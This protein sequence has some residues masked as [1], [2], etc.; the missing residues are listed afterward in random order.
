MGHAEKSAGKA[1]GEL[2]IPFLVFLHK[3]QGGASTPPI[4][5]PIGEAWTT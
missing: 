5:R 1:F 2:R 3:A 4:P